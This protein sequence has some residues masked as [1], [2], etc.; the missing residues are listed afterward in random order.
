MRQV[1]VHTRGDAMLGHQLHEFQPVADTGPRVQRVRHLGQPAL[2]QGIGIGQHGTGRQLGVVGP[3]MGRQVQRRH[4]AEARAGA[5]SQQRLGGRLRMAAR[6][7][8]PGAQARRYA[9]GVGA[10]RV[11]QVQH[12]GH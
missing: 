10:A 3:P 8:A 1:Q 11:L 6:A 2:L 5:R 9:L 4:V 12:I 7:V